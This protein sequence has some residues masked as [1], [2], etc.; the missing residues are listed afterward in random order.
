MCA[1]CCT[2]WSKIQSVL[3]LS[4]WRFYKIFF[5]LFLFGWTDPLT[6][7][8]KQHQWVNV[9]YRSNCFH[10]QQMLSNR[11]LEPSEREVTENKALFYS[12]SQLKAA[13][14]LQSSSSG[15]WVVHM[16]CPCL[17]HWTDSVLPCSCGEHG[18]VWA[19]SLNEISQVRSNISLYCLDPTGGLSGL[20]LSDPTTKGRDRPLTM[21]LEVCIVSAA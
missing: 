6:V 19:C 11:D 20:L 7:I 12:N 5:F 16:M 17:T 14:F 15:A 1:C 21:Q 4:S 9:L 2:T 13:A 18:Q 10:L 3:V 8:F